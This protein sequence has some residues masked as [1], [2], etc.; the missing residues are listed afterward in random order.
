[1]RTEEVGG[2][3]YPQ[4]RA[5]LGA[6]LAVSAV[7]GNLAAVVAE[8]RRPQSGQRSSRVDQVDEQVVF[9]VA[10]VI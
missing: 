5:R 6:T 9:N 7:R 8:R 4:K 2:S 1:M 3:S 10:R